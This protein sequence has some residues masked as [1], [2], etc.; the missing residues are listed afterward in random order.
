LLTSKLHELAKSRLDLAGNKGLPKPQHNATTY[1]TTFSELI[2]LLDAVTK[3]IVQDDKET[4]TATSLHKLGVSILAISAQAKDLE[5]IL[6]AYSKHFISH[7]SGLAAGQ[8][9][10]NSC[11]WDWMEE[12]KLQLLSVKEDLESAVKRAT[13][14]GH[15]LVAL[16]I[17]A[18][19]LR[20]SKKLW[21]LHGT[22]AEFLP[23]IKG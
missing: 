11:L 14:K 5:P 13:F 16:D 3:E 19:Y 23:I 20:H 9:P 7:G 6:Q 10:L 15:R 17:L 18:E 4:E 1:H 8:Y 12:A 2:K 21:K 22:M